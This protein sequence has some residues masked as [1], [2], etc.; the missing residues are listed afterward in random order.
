MNKFR[1]I[2]SQKSGSPPASTRHQLGFTLIELMIVVVIIGIL[3]A[4]GTLGYRKYL[5]M[6]K[7]AEARE[8][9]GKI[10]AAQESYFSERQQ[11]LDISGSGLNK[12]GFYPYDPTFNGRTKIQW[13]ADDSCT[14]AVNGASCAVNLKALGVSVAQPVMFRYASTTY[15]AAADLTDVSAYAPGFNNSVKAP[16]DGYVV[17]AVANLDGNPA[18]FSVMVGSEV[19]AD[20]YGEGLG[21]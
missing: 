3:A 8:I 19:Q 21:N 13:G 15:D 20:L 11:Y 1:K 6:S 17:V 2:Q 12:T 18:T 16:R 9:V 14:G 5:N 10:M 4:L 7:T